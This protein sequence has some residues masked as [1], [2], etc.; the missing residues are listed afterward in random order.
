MDYIQGW[1]VDKM[2]DGK[3]LET[4]HLTEEINTL[5]EEPHNCP[6]CNFR[7]YMGPASKQGERE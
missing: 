6:S 7:L 3:Y 1:G 2:E 5:E 4:A